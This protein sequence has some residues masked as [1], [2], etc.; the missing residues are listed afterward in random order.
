MTDR[1]EQ[2]G[3]K[4]STPDATKKTDAPGKP[5][6]PFVEV[7]EFYPGTVVIEDGIDHDRWF[8]P[9]PLR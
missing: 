2:H 1:K 8:H 6:E 5:R 7:L 4:E 3:E 9:L